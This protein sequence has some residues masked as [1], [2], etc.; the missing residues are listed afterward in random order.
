[1]VV[2]AQPLSTAQLEALGEELRRSAG[3]RVAVDVRV[4]PR[5]LGGIVVKLGSRLVD[6]S[7]NGRLR[8]LQSAMESAAKIGTRRYAA[9]AVLKGQRWRFVRRRFRRS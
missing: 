4:D 1:E 2:A 3:R 5:L 8:R 7:L 6:A 9:D